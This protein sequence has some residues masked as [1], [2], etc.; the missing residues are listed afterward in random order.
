[1]FICGP[2]IAN[3]ESGC[4]KGC[5]DRPVALIGWID[6]VSHRLGLLLGA[7]EVIVLC[8]FVCIV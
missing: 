4:L 1:M 3:Y 5:N 6:I 7:I 2:K 8:A